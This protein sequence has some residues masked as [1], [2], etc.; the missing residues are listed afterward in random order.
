M[1]SVGMEMEMKL[2]EEMGMGTKSD[3]GNG[4]GCE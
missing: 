2:L 4:M 3:D 1:S